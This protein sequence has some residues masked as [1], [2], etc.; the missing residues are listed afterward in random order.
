MFSSKKSS[1]GNTR[2]TGKFPSRHLSGEKHQSILQQFH[3]HASTATYEVSSPLKQHNGSQLMNII[4][5]ICKRQIIWHIVPEQRCF[6]CACNVLLVLTARMLQRR[7]ASP[8][9]ESMKAGNVVQTEPWLA[10]TLFV[11]L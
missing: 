5:F 4:T 7:S 11:I 9:I 2:M 6:L 8:H 3:T 1:I 10:D